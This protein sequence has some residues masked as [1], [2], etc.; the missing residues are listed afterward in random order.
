VLF[1]DRHVDY[2]GLS[3]R[4]KVNGS[5]WIVLDDLFDG[6][7]KMYIPLLNSFALLIAAVVVIHLLGVWARS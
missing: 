6:V 4:E 7:A 5:T 2:W 3:S 1:R